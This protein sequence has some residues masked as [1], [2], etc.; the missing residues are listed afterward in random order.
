MEN[1]E[2]LSKVSMYK[3][4]RVSVDRFVEYN[5]FISS[6]SSG[7]FKQTT[8]CGNIKSFSGWIPQYYLL[9]KDGKIITVASLLMRRT[10]FSFFLDLLLP[11]SCC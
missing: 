5:E 1:N 9:K 10:L 7:N 3:F 4:E 11:W 6:S 2:N 8:Y